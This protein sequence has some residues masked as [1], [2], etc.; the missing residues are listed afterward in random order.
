M[1]LT[2][3]SA[4]KLALIARRMREVDGPADYLRAEPIA[5]LGTACRFP[6]G[7]DTPEAFWD[8]LVSGRDAV[9]EIPPTRWN[10][11]A[12]YDADPEAPGRI[13][14][15][16]G[17]FLEDVDRFDAAFFGISPR[18]ATAMDPQQRI[19]LEVVWDA[20]ERAGQPA[21]RL[22]GTDAGVFI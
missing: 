11:D 7:A 6:G 2:D 14:T 3:L 1:A 22:R 18:E 9:T 13:S 20:L 4:E 15:R 12:F 10:I 16:W 19:L 17:G 8:L 21:P 5:I